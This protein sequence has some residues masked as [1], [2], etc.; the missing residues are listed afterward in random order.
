MVAPYNNPDDDGVVDF[1]YKDWIGSPWAHK[2]KAVK[3]TPGLY[4]KFWDMSLW[5][6]SSLA[7]PST[8]P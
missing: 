4:A 3:M 5:G 7:G 1:G 6:G 8:F 2:A